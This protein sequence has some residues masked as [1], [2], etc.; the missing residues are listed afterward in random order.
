MTDTAK[1]HLVLQRP[2]DPIVEMRKQSLRGLAT[3][4]PD[5]WCISIDGF[6]AF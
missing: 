4:N 3:L 1:E 5:L 6:K 2:P